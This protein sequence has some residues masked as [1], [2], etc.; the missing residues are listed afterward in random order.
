MAIRF[1]FMDDT[2]EIY[3]IRIG[4][5]K[6]MRKLYLF[7]RTLLLKCLLRYFEIQLLDETRA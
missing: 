4:K 6:I 3:V 2:Q 1:K 5:N 7:V